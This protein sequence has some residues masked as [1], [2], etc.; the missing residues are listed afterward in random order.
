VI[1]SIHNCISIIIL[2]S[3]SQKVFKD[4][5]FILIAIF[6][7]YGDPGYVSGL[8]SQGSCFSA[9]LMQQLKTFFGI[10]A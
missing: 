10:S 2:T 4:M 5:L 6:A 3:P 7:I 9:G 8:L 1:A